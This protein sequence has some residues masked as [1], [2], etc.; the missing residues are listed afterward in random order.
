[1]GTPHK[2]AELIKAWADGAKIQW[3]RPGD[4]WEDNIGTPGW[5]I[6]HTYRIKPE[7]KKV[8]LR[9]F[10]DTYGLVRCWTNSWSRDMKQVEEMSLFKRWVSPVEEREFDV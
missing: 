5:H 6:N 9:F 2:H 3:L 8:Q 7:P 10:E 1:M 4:V